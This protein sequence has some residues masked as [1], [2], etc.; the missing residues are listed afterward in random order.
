MSRF[1]RKVDGNHTAV[2]AALRA[3]GAWVADTSRLGGGFPDLLVWFRGRWHLLE[4][5]DGTLPP[6]A[7]KLTDAEQRFVERCPDKVHIVA[8]I[9]EALAAI[10]VQVAP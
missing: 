4:V 7:R 10:G 1:A 5:K 2:V 3:V 9:P 6:S 8:S